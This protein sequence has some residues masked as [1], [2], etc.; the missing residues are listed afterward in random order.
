[1]IGNITG[2]CH[3][4]VYFSDDFHRRMI[5]TRRR[6]KPENLTTEWKNSPVSFT[7]EHLNMTGKIRWLIRFRTKKFTC[8]FHRKISEIHK[9][10][11]L[12]NL[13]SY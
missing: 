3:R 13:T 10:T 12:A 8:Q 7:S 4:R 9:R 11:T 5:E 6:V 1:M 2:K